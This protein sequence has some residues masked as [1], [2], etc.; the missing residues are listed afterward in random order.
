MCVA[1]HTALSIK[2]YNIRREDFAGG[3]ES[4]RDFVFLHLKITEGQSHEKRK[5]QI[6]WDFL[7]F[8]L[9]G[10]KERFS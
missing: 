5:T 7:G 3:G 6:T 2:S 9:H 8:V 1:L 10:N 4:G